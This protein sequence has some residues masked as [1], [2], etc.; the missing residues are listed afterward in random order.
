MD[1]IVPR[2]GVSVD[3]TPGDIER[4][5]QT[6]VDN[7]RIAVDNLQKDNKTNPA[8]RT[9]AIVDPY[10]F[11]A[12]ADLIAV[13]NGQK[14]KAEFLTRMLEGFPK[15]SEMMTPGIVNIF[16]QLAD[17]QLKSFESWP[18]DMISGETEISPS[19]VSTC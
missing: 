15:S 6:I 4:D 9:L 5:A 12:V 14:E 8:F 11:S 16:Y 2:C 7:Y 13:L 17:A 19:R 18:V 10:L 3:V 1:S